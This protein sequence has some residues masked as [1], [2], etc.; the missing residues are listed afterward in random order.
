MQKEYAVINIAD[1]S[2]SQNIDSF[3][4]DFHCFAAKE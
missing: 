4:M 2:T 3:L 1:N